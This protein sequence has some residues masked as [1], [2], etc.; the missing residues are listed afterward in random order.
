MLAVDVNIDDVKVREVLAKAVSS[1]SPVSV[2]TAAAEGG[3]DVV[4]S[5]FLDL[6]KARHRAGQRIDY[7]LQAS[8]SVIRET[9]GPD[10]II[11]IP[12]TGIAQRLYGG[13]ILPSRRTSPVT[14]RPI[15]RLAIGLSG[16]PGE[17]HTPADFADL[18]VVTKKGSKKGSPDKGGAFL[19]RKTE[20]GVQRLFILL[21]EVSQD[22]DPSV[23]PTDDAILDSAES[24]ILD[25]YDASQEKIP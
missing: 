23:L 22:P 25:L 14:G 3:A 20:S 9:N 8:D 4:R 2:A 15:T 13:D 1:L 17:G 16:S 18:F 5:N 6:S 24:A 10:A 12:H 7:Y 19:A 21:R 11:R